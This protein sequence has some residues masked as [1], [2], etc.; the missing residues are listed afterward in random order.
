MKRNSGNRFIICLCSLCNNPNVFS[1]LYFVVVFRNLAILLFLPKTIAKIAR[2][3]YDPFV[4][5]DTMDAKKGCWA[6]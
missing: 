6:L 1:I 3:K 5:L 2:Q 4:R